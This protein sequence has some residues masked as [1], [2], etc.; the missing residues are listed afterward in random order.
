MGG[1]FSKRRRSVEVVK[2]SW[3]RFGA[4]GVKVVPGGAADRTLNPV[5]GIA[6]VY[7]SG[8]RLTQQLK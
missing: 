6:G 4:G 3:G 2:A 1:S 7:I 8:Y 5:H